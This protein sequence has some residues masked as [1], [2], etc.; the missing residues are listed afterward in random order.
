MQQGRVGGSVAG[1]RKRAEQ[2]LAQRARNRTLS[3][4]GVEPGSD[5]VPARGFA[6]GAGDADHPQLTRGMAIDEIGDGPKVRLEVR[7]RRMGKPPGVIPI[8]AVSL[9]E[10]RAGAT[11]DRV[12]DERSTVVARPGIRRKRIALADI[13]AVR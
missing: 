8:E 6:V 10:N 7:E 13:T 11:S 3:A 5:P 1:R 12:G 9:P 4:G 2:S